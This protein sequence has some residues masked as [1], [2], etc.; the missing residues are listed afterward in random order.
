ME[1]LAQDLRLAARNLRKQPAF[2]LVAVLT[3][4]V[5]IGANTAIF[6]VVNATLLRPFPFPQPDELMRV[7]MTTPGHGDMPAE[8]DFI[9]SYPKYRTFRELQQ[10][11]ENASTYRRQSFSLTGLDQAYRIS[12]EMVD[13]DY[14]PVLGVS[15][16]QG[17]TFLAEEN[18]T[19]G[20]H[21]VALL[22]HGLWERL[23]GADPAVIGRS[24][25][26]NN[27]D[28]TVVGVLTPGFRGLTGQGEVWIPSMTMDAQ[29]L[30]EVWSHTHQVIARRKPGVSVEQAKQA[31]HNLG[32][33][34]DEAHPA[35]FPVDPFGAKAWTLAEARIDPRLQQSVLVLFGA[36]AL[37]LLIAC[38]NI[39]NLLLVR[40][41]SRRREIAIRLAVGAGR[42]R[43]VRQ[44]LTES[45][46]LAGLGALAGVGLAA[47]GVRLLTSID[48][49][50]TLG[51]NASGLTLIGLDSIRIDA[52]AALFAVLTATAAALLFGLAPALRSSRPDI[53]EAL[54]AAGSRGSAVA[55]LRALKGR[56]LLVAAQ[57]AL[58]LVL[59]V[60]SGLMI[61]S[62]S[63]LLSS[64]I[65]FD[66]DNLLSLRISLPRGQYDQESGSNFWQ[67][68][69]ERLGSL[70][71]V[72]SVGLGSCPPLSGG[73]NST[74]I[75]FPDRPPVVRGT[76]PIVSVF[77][78][79]P[80]YFQTLGTPL[81]RGRLF[82]DQDRREAPK[83][84][85]VNQT[86][87]RKFWPGDDP[88]GKTI[89]VGQGGFHEGAQVVGI[90][91]DV[92]YEGMD[93]LPLPDVF[94]PLTQSPRFS[95]LVHLRSQGDPIAL[96]GF[97]RAEVQA[98]DPNLPL[99]DIRTMHDRRSLS[100]SRMR[101][102]ATLLSLF[103]AM[104]MVLAV[105]GIYGVMSYSVSQG[106][107]SIGIRM[108][109]GATSADVLRL[110]VSR[111]AAM[112]LA[113]VG[114]GLA[115]AYGA[116]RVLR[117]LLFEVEPGDPATY[118]LFGVGLSFVALAACYLPARRA[119]RVDPLS[120]LRSE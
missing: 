40:G 115:A 116:S 76:E 84:V 102:S 26:L 3:L 118:A 27:R 119:T 108:A 24:V 44:L 1:T 64:E 110:V 45:L 90:V 104:A 69:T 89:G 57:V 51:L 21:F 97:V 29:S 5:G 15:A 111:G 61:K 63:R 10:V 13:A 14:F 81:I 47:W 113:G 112:A 105:L 16:V 12:G 48:P 6:S 94:L 33:A 75:L 114:I 42:L 100:S 7:S 88:I 73:C 39:A 50:A 77:W 91:G 60:G 65:G 4:A 32:R 22:G 2:A 103:G 98:L 31:I 99:Y 80:D 62:L 19:P 43:L 109:L 107:R 71:A 58:A 68:L 46:L 86:A 8:D 18:K 28:Y 37:V 55:G 56:S 49:A 95:T 78:A 9:W 117:A 79:S 96:V 85:V 34:I 30:Q 11:F 54:K 41:A 59:L 66:P 17:R 70:P 106:T 67:Q 74:V 25:T 93:S 23:F 120:T 92:R 82:N 38:V 83:V 87:A 20:T 72:R 53:S 52:A 101:F 35:P 36:V